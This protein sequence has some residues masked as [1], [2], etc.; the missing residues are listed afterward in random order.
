METEP[1]PSTDQVVSEDTKPEPPLAEATP[2]QEA[3]K[4][5][6]EGSEPPAEAMEEE[7][8]LNT[9]CYVKADSEDDG[10]CEEEG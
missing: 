3:D 4:T 8:K 2:T 5:T 1:T 7:V 9:H 6:G 10:N